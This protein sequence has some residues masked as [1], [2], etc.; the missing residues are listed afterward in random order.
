MRTLRPIAGLL[1]LA[2]LCLIAAAAYFYPKIPALAVRQAEALLSD[3]GVQSIA[4]EGPVVGTRQLQLETLKLQGE[5]DGLAFTATLG[6]L[7][8]S[9]NWRLLLTGRFGELVLDEADLVLEQLP[10]PGQPS[11]TT[12]IIDQLLPHSLFQQL[13]LQSIAIRHLALE[14]RSAAREPVTAAGNLSLIGQRLSLQLSS[15]YL[16]STI[17][18]HL[19]TGYDATPLSLS[20]DMGYSDS[21]MLSLNAQLLRESAQLWQWDIDGKLEWETLLSWLQGSAKDAIGLDYS[22]IESLAIQGSS[23]LQAVFQHPN[24][25]HTVPS[26]ELQPREQLSGNMRVGNSVSDLDYPPLVDS[27][28]GSVDAA[29]QLERGQWSAT[30]ATE[31]LTGSLYAGQLSLTPESLQWLGWQ[32]LI[33][34]SFKG[35]GDVHT[36][37]NEQGSW[38][39]QLAGTQLS[40]GNTKSQVRINGLQLNTTMASAQQGNVDAAITASLDTR[41]RN[42]QL[43][44]MELDLNHQGPLEQ[45]DLKLQLGDTAESIR[46]HINGSGNLK[47]GS[48]RYEFKAYSMD[49]P[50]ASSTLVPLLRKFDLLE[51]DLALH[52]GSFKLDS[53]I[54]SGGFSP[55][56]WR[57]TSNLLADNL[58]GN[59]DEFRFSGVSLKANWQGMQQWRTLA[60]IEFSVSSLDIGFLITDLRAT[61]TLPQLTAPTQPTVRIEDFSAKVFGG[62]FYLPQAHTWDFSAP[63]NKLTLKAE[64]WQLAELVALQQDQQIDAQ[65]ELEGELPIILR[66][67]RIIIDKG[68]LKAS[69]SGGNIRY[70]PNAA[71]QALA[72]S[73]PELGMAM[74]LLR[75]FRYEVLSSEVELDQAGNLLLG[76]SLGGR[77]P[78]K[79]EGR[80]VNFNINLEQN[81]DPLLQ[82]LRLSDTLVEKIEERLQ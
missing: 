27:L 41:L 57:M 22:S 48:G 18:G 24:T 10:G 6:G 66:D 46:L 45:G 59:V 67:G 3:H 42:T 63:S 71:T 37:S 34:V 13:P 21:N 64:H 68:Y 9:Y 20:L 73:S 76:L 65:G 26:G 1:I 7:H 82:S 36:S 53:V 77:N 31:S 52:S 4:F 28:N 54:E 12:I 62:R 32:P 25:L 56:D 47:T 58:M 23:T 60:P 19:Q 81:L 61:A 72:E 8:L 44:R 38:S 33:P 80:Q 5:M 51:Q 49:L 39:A 30:F 35:R 78:G 79:Y 55:E 14:H 15:L 75:D 40:L 43:P 2:L 16:G 50:Y 29:V 17:D 70:T 74:D 69:G 11:N